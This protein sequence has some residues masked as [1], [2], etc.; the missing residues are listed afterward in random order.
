MY[1]ITCPSTLCS[2]EPVDKVESCSP[3]CN[4]MWPGIPIEHSWE[5]TGACWSRCTEGRSIGKLMS[6][7]TQIDFHFEFLIKKFNPRWRSR[8]NLFRGLFESVNVCSAIKPRDLTH[9]NSYQCIVF[10]WIMRKKFSKQTNAFIFHISEYLRR[11]DFIKIHFIK[12]KEVL[13]GL[14]RCF[15][16]CCFCCPNLLYLLMIKHLGGVFV[17][18]HHMYKKT[19]KQKVPQSL[20]LWEKS[21]EHIT[22]LRVPAELQ[23]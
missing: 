3:H 8:T 10:K 7:Q 13:H 15:N 22:W 9:C 1:R 21:W 6:N 23:P 19:R 16:F 18:L 20:R 2:P 5:V 17:I 4:G 11:C 12:I 14:L